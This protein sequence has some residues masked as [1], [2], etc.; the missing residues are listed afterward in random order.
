MNS[1]QLSLTSVDCHYL[2]LFLPA[3]KSHFNATCITQTQLKFQDIFWDMVVM[4]AHVTKSR[5][6]LEL[7]DAL[8]LSNPP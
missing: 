8:F 5:V 2:T 7:E 4:D 1:N 3:Y 6:R